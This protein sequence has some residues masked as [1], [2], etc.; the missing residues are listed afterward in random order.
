GDPSEAFP[1]FLG[2]ADETGAGAGAGATLNLPLPPGTGW[3]RWSAALDTALTRIVAHG[4]D[5][6]IVSLGVDAYKDDPI[7]FFT[8]ETED[9]RR[10]GARLAKAG[11]P[12]VFVMEGGYAIAEIGLNVA[13]VL[14]AFEDA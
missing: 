7:S 9:F 1:H 3:D 11:L 10:L 8:L 4:V 6:L 5:G 12:T 14:R 13:A 2:G